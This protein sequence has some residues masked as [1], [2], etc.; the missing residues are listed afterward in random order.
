MYAI[1]TPFD[2][3]GAVHVK[4]GLILCDGSS[5]QVAFSS[6][7]PN[8]RKD[9]SVLGYLGLVNDFKVA[10]FHLRIDHLLHCLSE[11]ISIILTHG[12]VMVHGVG[13]SH[14]L[15]RYGRILVLRWS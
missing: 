14:R 3:S 1:I 5:C 6:H 15:V 12:L 8:C 9:G 4:S 7:F 13:I 10:V 2:L 11:F